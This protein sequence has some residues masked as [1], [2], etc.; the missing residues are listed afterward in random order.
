MTP[1]DE[2]SVRAQYLEVFPNKHNE[3]LAA[4]PRW[5]HNGDLV[6][7]VAALG[8]MPGPVIDLTFGRGRFWKSW[9]PEDFTTNDLNP[10]RGADLAHD[11]TSLPSELHG[12]FRTVVF[13]PDYKDT[14]T[15]SKLSDNADYG[16]SGRVGMGSTGR[17]DKVLAGA[18][19]AALVAEVGGWVHVKCQ[20]QTAR[21]RFNDHAG[22]VVA[23]L[24][25]LGL[26]H[27]AEWQFVNG[28]PRPHSGATVTPRNN[29]SQLLSFRVVRKVS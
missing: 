6:W 27:V 11:Y 4:D 13:D 28:S 8:W 2:G 10:D 21:F 25:G 15:A 7:A 19:Q 14:G 29:T 26:R 24:E 9:R 18:T 17:M 20:N 5:R 23:H 12:R 1:V 3:V 22:R 16:V